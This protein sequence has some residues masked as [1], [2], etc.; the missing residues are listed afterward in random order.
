MILRKNIEAHMHVGKVYK[1]VY[2]RLLGYEACLWHYAKDKKLG[3]G[4]G[5]CTGFGPQSKY[6]HSVIF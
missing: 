3:V 6:E 1:S 4:Y 5:K 2:I